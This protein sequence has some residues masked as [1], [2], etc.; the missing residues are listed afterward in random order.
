MYTNRGFGSYS[1]APQGVA[2]SIAA[3]IGASYGASY[4]KGITSYAA[5]PTSYA[6]AS[7]AAS[8]AM[9]KVISSP[10][11]SFLAAAPF[12][13]TVAAPTMTMAPTYGATYGTGAKVISSPLPASTSFTTAPTTYRGS[14]MGST[15]PGITSYAAPTATV[16]AYAGMSSSQLLS[17]GTVVSERIISMEEAMNNGLVRQEVYQGLMEPALVQYA[18]PAVVVDEQ[19]AVDGE[20]PQRPPRV[21]IICTSADNMD[22]TPTGAWSE[23]ITGP[24]YQFMD[25]GCETFIVS[26]MGGKVPIDEGSLSEQ[27]FTENDKRFQEENGLQLLEN[28]ASIND[29]VLDDIDCIFMAGGHGT[30][31]DFPNGLAQLV[32]DASAMGK[33]V[34][35][36][37]HGVTG[38]VGAITPEG[39]PLLQGRQVTGFSNE[40]EVAVNLHEKV[41]FLCQNQMQELGAQYVCGEPWSEFAVRDGSLVTG[42]NPQ[43]SVQ[44]ARLCLE[45]MGF[46]FE[47]PPQQ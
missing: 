5:M 25:A 37:C 33:V 9:G 36:V 31:V 13:T 14:T 29:I 7:Y 23:E 38:L 2:S 30:C 21:I 44:A 43:S 22:G 6:G 10:S 4:G 39:L 26:V 32:T 42:Q 16:G 1:V 11:P 18:E 19:V 20:V 41:P 35:A 12:A 34:G 8:P 46:T 45:A 40:E 15:Y 27:F 24:F 17:M 3:P 28:T 47:P